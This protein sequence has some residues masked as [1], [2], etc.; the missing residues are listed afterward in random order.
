VRLFRTSSLIATCALAVAACART[1][2]GSGESESILHASGESVDV[3]LLDAATAKPIAN[4]AVE[5]QSDNGI[6]CIKAPC[7]TD[8]KQW[9]GTSDA[10]GRVTI[11]RSALNTTANIKT[12]GYDGDL[13][14]DATSDATGVWSVDLF[15]DGCADKCPHPL[16]LHDARSHEPIANALVLI[17]VRGDTT[18]EVASA[19]SNALGYVFVPFVIMA[20]GVEDSWVIVEGYRDA[21]IDFAA[22]RQKIL[23]EPR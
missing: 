8:A 2:M 3:R 13:V 15:S 19:T 11:P 9:K 1:Q 22:A 4:T 6:R 20:K 5:V 17:E 18:H 10:N 23:L 12:A 16:K 7:P 14:G 21:K